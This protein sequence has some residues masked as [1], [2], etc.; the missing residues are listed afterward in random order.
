MT[1]PLDICSALF[2]F[3]ISFFFQLCTMFN[4]FS[5]S[6]FDFLAISSPECSISVSYWSQLHVK[7]GDIKNSKF[8]K[9]ANDLDFQRAWETSV[10]NVRLLHVLTQQMHVPMAQNSIPT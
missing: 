3:R 1:R 6:S 10:G 5:L 2:M 4:V 7:I 9:W 8:G